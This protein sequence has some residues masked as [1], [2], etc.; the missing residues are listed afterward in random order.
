MR[1]EPKLFSKAMTMRSL[2]GT[3]IEDD[4]VLSGV[5]VELMLMSKL[6][7]SS[8]VMPTWPGKDCTVPRKGSHFGMGYKVRWTVS[9][10]CMET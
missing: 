6:H 8:G 3:A 10:P 1:S 9:L 4:H 2:P 7:P 5:G